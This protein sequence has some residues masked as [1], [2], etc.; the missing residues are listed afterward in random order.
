MPN[1]A[2]RLIPNLIRTL[3]NPPKEVGLMR[4]FVSAARSV[5]TGQVGLLLGILHLN[6][7]LFWL[8]GYAINPLSDEEL[9]TMT[10]YYERVVEF[11][12]EQERNYWAPELL[13]KSDEKLERITAKYQE[14]LMSIL[15]RVVSEAA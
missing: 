8:K 11:P 7:Y 14:K 3:M 12:L 5:T 15:S 9:I 6:K 4:K 10:A 2:S 13:R 1:L